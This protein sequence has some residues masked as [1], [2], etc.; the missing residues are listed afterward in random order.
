MIN[1]T[2]IKI[3]SIPKMIKKACLSLLSA[4]ETVK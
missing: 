3:N 2:I 1:P 4:F